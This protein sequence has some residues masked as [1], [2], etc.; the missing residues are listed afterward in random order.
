MGRLVLQEMRESVGYISIRDRKRS[1]GEVVFPECFDRRHD[2]REREAFLLDTPLGI[3][4]H[5]FSV[6]RR[7]LRHG[8]PKG[9][10]GPLYILRGVMVSMQACPTLRATMSADG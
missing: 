8:S 2:I 5:G 4:P 1:I 9:L 6:L 10:P 3:N 7:S